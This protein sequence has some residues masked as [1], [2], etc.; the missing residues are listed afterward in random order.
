MFDGRLRREVVSA[1][2]MSILSALEISLLAEIEVGELK[3]FK[4]LG[5]P[6]WQRNRVS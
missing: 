1:Q 5:R 3:M 2:N 6:I 4:D